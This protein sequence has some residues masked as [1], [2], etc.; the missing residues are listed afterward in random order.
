M[1]KFRLIGRKFSEDVV[2]KD[3]GLVPYKII[4]AKNGDREQI[5]YETADLWFHSMVMLANQGLS[6]DDGAGPRNGRWVLRTARARR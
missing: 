4:A 5:I 3:Q 2:Q 1:G 6:A